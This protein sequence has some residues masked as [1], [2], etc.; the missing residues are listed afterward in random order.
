MLRGTS[1]GSVASRERMRRVSKVFLDH[2]PIG[3]RRR[4]RWTRES[5]EQR[6]SR[7]EEQ[8][9]GE[10]LDTAAEAFSSISIVSTLV[11]GFGISSF[12]SLA[13]LAPDPE[14][15]HP[16]W[17]PTPFTHRWLVCV[18]AIAMVVTSGLSG[19][20]TIFMTLTY[21]YLKRLRKGD[22]R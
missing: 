12:V 19:F 5:G 6:R 10:N 18:F 20:A 13:G 22:P 2:I 1:N 9:K 15:V 8:A 14:S 3:E 7:E 11:F 21:Y 4:S 16:P 17:G